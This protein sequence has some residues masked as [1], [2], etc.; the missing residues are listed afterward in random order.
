MIIRSFHEFIDDFCSP[1]RIVWNKGR[2]PT[3]ERKVIELYHSIVWFDYEQ[4]RKEAF[5][6]VPPQKT[7]LTK[8]KRKIAENIF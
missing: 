5:S 1:L 4:G 3:K 7:I 6:W 2:K 8:L